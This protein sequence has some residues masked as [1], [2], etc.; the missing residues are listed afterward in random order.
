MIKCEL[1]L[2]RDFLIFDPHDALRDPMIESI[3]KDKFTFRKTSGVGITL[4]VY[5]T[6]G[7]SDLTGEKT[8]HDME[9]RLGDEDISNGLPESFLQELVNECVEN[10]D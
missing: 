3:H 9:V 4:R 5:G 7:I 10:A 6:V 1:L 2:E 8:V